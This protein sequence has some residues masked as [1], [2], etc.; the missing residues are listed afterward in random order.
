MT[1]VALSIRAADISAFVDIP[2]LAVL[3]KYLLALVR[4][5]QL[6]GCQAVTNVGSVGTGLAISVVMMQR[7][8]VKTMKIAT[9]FLAALLFAGTLGSFN[10]AIAEDGTISKDSL[11]SDPYCHEKFP[12]IRQ[13]TLGDDQPALK[14]S[15]TGDV[16]DFYG[17]CDEN[18]VGKDQVQAQRLDDQHRWE[19]EYESE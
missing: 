3:E 11:T 7:K 6:T 16:I 8:E 12:A 1:M 13:S 14:N 10:S 15:S 5:L 4:Q 2:T 9:S 19:T 18:P 17:P